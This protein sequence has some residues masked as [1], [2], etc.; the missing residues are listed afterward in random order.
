MKPTLSV[1]DVNFEHN[2]IQALC[3][4]FHMI[5]PPLDKSKHG[6]RADTW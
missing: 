4:T 6:G 1:Q 2:P 5:T 3:T